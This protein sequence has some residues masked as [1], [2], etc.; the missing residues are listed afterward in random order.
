MSLTLF[1]ISILIIRISLKK[2]SD[3]RRFIK[4]I[5]QLLRQITLLRIVIIQ[6][7]IILKYLIVLHIL[8][9]YNN[10]L[11]GELIHLR[12]LFKLRYLRVKFDLLCCR[13][14]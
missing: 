11:T 10:C 6:F 14:N 3:F 4:T 12:F 2:C 5:I 8:Q 7:S 13:L 9:T 1:N